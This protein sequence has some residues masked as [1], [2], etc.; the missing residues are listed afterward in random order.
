MNQDGLKSF[1][2]VAREKSISKA[3]QSLYMTQPALS[4]RIRKLEEAL[5]F[6]LLERNWDGAKLTK[7]GYYF[8]M[9]A[10]QLVQD[11]NDSSTLLKDSFNE[12]LISSY[13]E[14]TNQTDYLL[15]GIDTWLT[16]LFAKPIIHILNTRF[17][18]LKFR[19]ITRPTQVIVDLVKSHGIHVGIHYYIQT[20]PG[21]HNHPLIEKD[22]LLLIYPERLG[23][24]IEP[25]IRNFDEL[26]HLPFLLFDNP[27]LLTH[28]HTTTYLIKRLD[29]KKIQPVDDL[30]VAAAYI[31]EGRAYT[32]LPES[33]FLPV[34]GGQVPDVRILS[35][36]EVLSSM[37]AQMIYTLSEPFAEAV[38]CVR[39]HL[40]STSFEFSY[41]G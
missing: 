41:H 20:I 28:R 29:I 40:T 8:L 24:E 39:Q 3:A 10:T 14:V 30:H 2:A 7:Q 13:E 26:Q 6:P 23:V 22:G 31:S 33:C 15:I 36:K 27:V 11:L 16:P 34:F 18:K 37:S 38:E 17:P 21:V 32:I 4:N 12:R 5:G 19:F 1:L 35:L 9:Y 25:D